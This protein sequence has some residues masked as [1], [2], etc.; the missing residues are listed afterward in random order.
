[1]RARLAKLALRAGPVLPKPPPYLEG[2]NQG[3]RKDQCLEQTISTIRTQT[4]PALD[5]IHIRAPLDAPGASSINLRKRGSAPRIA[6]STRCD[7]TSW[8]RA[9][10]SGWTRGSPARVS[11]SEPCCSAPTPYCGGAAMTSMPLIGCS[12]HTLARQF[13]S[14]PGFVFSA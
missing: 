10:A 6:N 9:A 11:M 13:L 1:M 12:S 7:P 4:E 8:E 2:G 5:P 14:F 3:H